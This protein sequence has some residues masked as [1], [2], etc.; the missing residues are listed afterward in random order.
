MGTVYVGNRRH[1]PASV[2]QLAAEVWWD[3]CSKMLQRYELK[4]YPGIFLGLAAET[5]SNTKGE[6]GRFLAI[7]SRNY[8]K[9]VVIRRYLSASGE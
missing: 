3:R 7:G 6:P 9:C 4:G 5:G 8:I 1:Q 2:F